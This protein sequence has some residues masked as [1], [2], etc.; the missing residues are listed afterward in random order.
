MRIM[1][2]SS[3]I[4]RWRAVR[5]THIAVPIQTDNEA[6]SGVAIGITRDV[7]LNAA[8]ATDPYKTMTAPASRKPVIPRNCKRT[9][10]TSEVSMMVTVKRPNQLSESIRSWLSKALRKWRWMVMPSTVSLEGKS[11]AAGLSALDSITITTALSWNQEA[12]CGSS[13]LSTSFQTDDNGI[14]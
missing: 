8:M 14:G 3:K 10:A 4:R 2:R 9:H 1:S 6:M 7:T 12:N 13:W 11:H 5:F